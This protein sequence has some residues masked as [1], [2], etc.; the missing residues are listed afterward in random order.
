M[1]IL[2]GFEELAAKR[3]LYSAIDAAKNYSTCHRS[4]CGAV[5]VA[6]DKDL[7]SMI[8]GSGYNSAPRNC[9]LDEC[10][11]AQLPKGFKSDKTCCIHAEQRAIRDADRNYP[12][13]VSGSTLYF[14][15]LDEHNEPK[16]SG[17]PYCTMCS[18]ASLDAGIG[19]FVLLHPTG[20]EIKGLDGLVV[21]SALSQDSFVA[22]P[23]EE[24][25]QLSFLHAGPLQR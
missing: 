18:K 5:L 6:T 2:E 11:K 3:W 9:T 7:R 24:Y 22:Y 17:H 19:E 8:I 10:F 20:Y 13:L 14:I 23:A 25:N 16:P 12:A 15:R 4:K 1:R 21:G